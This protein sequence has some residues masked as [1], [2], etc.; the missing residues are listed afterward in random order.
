MPSTSFRSVF[1]AVFLGTALVIVAFMINRARPPHETAQPGAQF[2]LA[3]GK[4]SE[5]HR[6]QTSAIVHEYEMS[7]HSA[8]G[9]NCLDCHQPMAGQEKLEHRGFA[10]AKSLTAANCQQ[11]HRTQYEQFL[12]SRHAAPAWAAVSGPKDFTPEQIAFA[13]TY[14]KGAVS[15]PANPLVGQE[16][17]AAVNKGCYQCHSVGKPNADLTIGTC[18]ACHA[19]HVAS[20]E[21]ARNPRTCGQCHMGPDHSQIEIYEES[22]H[23]I[24]FASQRRPFQYG[25]PRR[26]DHHYGPARPHLR[27]LPHGRSGRYRADP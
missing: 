22:K 7:K 15:R 23:G 26:Q 11:C 24:L 6:Q 3:T 8:K 19:R 20:V 5:C 17:P 13:E 16:G 14:H 4:C 10:I 27:H 25:R 18:T 2:V 12:R 9:I 1:I 21:L